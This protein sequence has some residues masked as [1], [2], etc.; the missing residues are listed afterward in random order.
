M[1]KR[2]LFIFIFLS[3]C[4]SAEVTRFSSHSYPPTSTVEVFTD[5]LSIKRDFVEIGYVE[6]SG[7]ITITKQQLLDDMIEKAKIEGANALVKVEFWDTTE[8]NYAVKGDVH[9]PR[10]KA[11]MIRYK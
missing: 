9:K 11:T 7:G 6:A 1:S 3:G 4:H 8:Y 5:A 2:I 10:A